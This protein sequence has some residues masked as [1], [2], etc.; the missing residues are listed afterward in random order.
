MI[1]AMKPKRQQALL[2]EL[3]SNKNRCIKTIAFRKVV[4]AC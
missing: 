2:N 3:T 1:P 4:A